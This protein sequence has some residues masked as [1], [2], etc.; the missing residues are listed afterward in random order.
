MNIW[1]KNIRFWKRAIYPPET[2]I[3]VLFCV[4][5]K[6]IIRSV[7]QIFDTAD[8]WEA[9]IHELMVANVGMK[10]ILQITSEFLE[11]P[12]AVMGADFSLVAEAGKEY[13]PEKARLYTE[14][15]L[16]MEYMN[17][18]LQ[19]ESYQKMAD[20]H[21]T[22]MFPAYI[23]G[24]RSM[25]RNLFTDGK[26]THRLVLTECRSTIA[27]GDSCILEAISEKLEFLLSHEEQQANPDKDLEQ[28]TRRLPG[29]MI[30]HE[31]LLELK[32]QDEKNHTEYMQ[33][34]KV[35]L[36]QHLSATQA[37]RELFIHR[38]TFLYRLEKIK[39]IL[40]SDLE[41]AEEIFYLELSFR[42]LEQ[43]EE[44]S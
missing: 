37:A 20:T 10:K 27:Q 17:A 40:Q 41:D 6:R 12:L 25:N 31:G 11:N 5:E 19:D 24:C 28:S 16:N 38:S 14:D 29:K 39:E 7:Q 9:K 13:L 8:E 26:P 36:E 42:L 22:V 2:D 4:T 18:L 23:S 30:C 34:L 33:T 43:E 35:Y 3:C 15:G 44:K 21:E 1:K 32:E